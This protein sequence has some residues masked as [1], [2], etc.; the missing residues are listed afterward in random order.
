MIKTSM[1]VSLILLPEP[2]TF[3]TPHLTEL[4]NPGVLVSIMLIN[5]SARKEK[6]LTRSG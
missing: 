3:S 2:Q 4:P 5:L 1:A 6:T